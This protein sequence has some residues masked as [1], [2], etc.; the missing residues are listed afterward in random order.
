MKIPL[1][2][3]KA[4]YLSIKDE[5]D[6]AVKRVINNSS[7]ILGEEVEK[8]ER[9]FADYLG[10]RFC[11]GVASGTDALYL[12]MRIH[13][14]RKN[15]EVNIPTRN[16]TASAEMAKMLGARIYFYDQKPEL[17]AD[18]TVM[19]HL[20]GK[21]KKIKKS[22]KT[23]IIEDCAQAAGASIKGRKCGTFG[24]VSVFSFFPSKPLG[25]MGDGGAVVIYNKNPQKEI[26]KDYAE[27]IYALRNHGRAKGQKYEHMDIGINSRLDG[28]Q[29]AILNAKLPYLNKWISMRAKAAA[30]YNDYLKGISQVSTPRIKKGVIRSWYVYA[31]SAERR[32]ELT[33]YLALKGIQTGVHY[34][35]PVH[36]Q[37]PFK[38]WFHLPVEFPE[39]DKWAAT[40]LSL[41]MHPFLKSDQIEYVCEHVRKF[42]ET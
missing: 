17:S 5:I 7:F 6:S 20:Y 2:D 40:T 41:P 35:I 39:A 14:I 25:C 9:N 12:A 21:P 4:E 19:V 28:L 8:F 36:R 22:Y 24:D 15:A 29:A 27:R 1:C 16:V 37:P 32:D 3:L 31:I 33:A 18:A 13:G 26:Y 10:A 11:I 42:Y 23:W 38:N 34:P 30:R